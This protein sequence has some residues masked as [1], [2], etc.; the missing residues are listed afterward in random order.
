VPAKPP[1]GLTVTV[2]E[3]VAPART[4]KVVGLVVM[5][6]S[7]M[8]R[9]KLNPYPVVPEFP[10]PPTLF[11]EAVHMEPGFSVRVLEEDP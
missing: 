7:V 5:L 6:K 9:I 4:V 1:S 3:A 11:E 8:F 2:E 10:C